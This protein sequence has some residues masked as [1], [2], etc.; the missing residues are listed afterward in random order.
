MNTVINTKIGINRGLARF[1]IEGRKIAHSFKPGDRFD[2]NP[3]KQGKKMELVLNSEGEYRVYKRTKNNEVLP[4]IELKGDVIESVFEV[5]MLLRVV[6]RNGKITIEIHGSVKKQMLR[7]SKFLNKLL[8]KEALTKGSL[9]TG[10]GVLDSAIN[11]GLSNAGIDSY[12]KFIVERE[13]KYV[14]AFLKNQTRGLFREDL[15]IVESPIEA[16][17]FKGEICV[18]ILVSSLPCT[19]SS[20]AGKTKNKIKSAELHVDAGSAFYYWLN[21]IAFC[22]PTL[23]IMENV[24]EFSNELSMSVIRSVL[25]NMGYDLKERN[26]GGNDFGCLENRNRMCFIAISKG[27][28]DK[29]DFSLD[30]V[31]PIQLKESSVSEIMDVVP[32]DDKSWKSYSY[33]VDKEIRDKESGK[34]FG[35]ELIDG[36]EEKVGTIR[37][38]YN[39]GGSCDQFVKHPKFDENGLSRLFTLKEHARLKKIPEFL[40]SGLSATIGHELLGQSVCYPVFESVGLSL[41]HWFNDLSTI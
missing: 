21:F 2:V 33:L 13:R 40:I 23:I 1:W 28:T 41:G 24:V 22:Q 15:I 4:L 10:L 6:A 7:V 20:K 12:T 35:R 5:S 16:V 25:D 3:D 37:R 36:T 38:L 8:K 18:D 34:G 11:Q 29:V 30:S 14:D 9:F 32:E 19:G 27:L 26:L 17:E 31:L 39:K